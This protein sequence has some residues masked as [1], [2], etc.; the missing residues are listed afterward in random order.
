MMSQ[1]SPQAA[2]EQIAAQRIAAERY[3]LAVVAANEIRRERTPRL[4]SLRENRSLFSM[5]KRVRVA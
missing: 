4:P 5:R 1:L 2:R 3:H